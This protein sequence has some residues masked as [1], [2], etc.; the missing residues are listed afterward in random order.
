[1]LSI[2]HLLP[3]FFLLFRHF[4]LYDEISEFIAAVG[5]I[6][7]KPGVFV[8]SVSYLLA[9]STPLEVILIACIFDNSNVF[10][11]LTLV[12]SQPECG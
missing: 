12:P 9:V 8:D 7:P 3:S 11:E 6:T 4:T 5:L 1:M 10:A 2:S